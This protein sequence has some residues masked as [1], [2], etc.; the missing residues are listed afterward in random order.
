M[1][2]IAGIFTPISSF[3]TKDRLQ[4]MN[5]FGKNPL[6]NLWIDESNSVGFSCVYSQYLHY[7]IAFDGA[8]YNAESIRKELTSLGYQFPHTE[9]AI[10]VMAAYDYWKEKCMEHF[11]GAF[12]FAIYNSKDESIILT[13]D[14]LGEKQ[15]FYYGD[16]RERG[17]FVQLMFASNINAL[18]KIGAPKN[19][20]PTMLLNYLTLGYTGNPNKKM[21]TFYSDIL[22]LPPGNYLK[23][24]PKEGRTQMRNWYRP[25]IQSIE[26]I[27]DQEAT[28]RFDELLHTSIS[29]TINDSDRFGICSDENIENSV[30]NNTISKKIN[31]IVRISPKENEF[32]DIFS[33]FENLCS[34]QE[35]PFYNIDIFFQYITLQNANQQGVDTI[36]STIGANEIFGGKRDYVVYYLQ[37][38]LKDNYKLFLQ[39]KKAFQ[40]NGFLDNWKIKNYFNAFTAK[41]TAKSA[42][43]NLVKKQNSFPFINE[44]FLMRYQNEDSLRQPEIHRPE[45][46]MFF[47]AFTLGLETQLKTISKI[48]ENISLKIKHPYLNYQLVEYLLALASNFKFRDGYDKWILRSFAENN[49]PKTSAW[50]NDHIKNPISI[51]FPEDQLQDAKQKLLH[52]KIFNKKILEKTNYDNKNDVDWRIVNIAFFIEKNGF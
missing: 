36:L 23:I 51:F 46:A 5:D 22:S 13:R 4:K 47:D 52:H 3:L 45:D 1:A 49:F 12:A 40:Q 43:E 24:F 17:R 37:Y 21:T 41:K 30:L 29:Q 38:L 10:L 26:N 7:M 44:D 33:L 27:T 50:K 19:L 35:E 9:D 11:E 15:L 20:D 2:F 14:R 18:W 25:N 16:F 32:N 39:E 34:A 42:Q 6:E 28:D 8:I 48:A 31:H